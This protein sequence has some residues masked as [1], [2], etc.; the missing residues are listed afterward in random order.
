MSCKVLLQ[1]CSAFQS[2]LHSIED[3]ATPMDGLHWHWLSGAA[4]KISSLLLAP[5]IAPGIAP[6][7]NPLRCEM[8]SALASS[9]AAPASPWPAPE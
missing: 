4:S 2:I 5:G 9:L 6:H 8:P 3:A 7:L 1:D